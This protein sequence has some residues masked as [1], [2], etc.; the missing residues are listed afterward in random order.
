[1]GTM[2]KVCPSISLVF[3]GIQHGDR[4]PCGVVYDRAGFFENN[5][6][7]PKMEKIRQA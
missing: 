6:F 7:A 4:G 2:N 5:I 1:M 3:S